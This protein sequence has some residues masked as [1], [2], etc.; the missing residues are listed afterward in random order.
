MLTY[1][2]SEIN[3]PYIAQFINKQVKENIKLC[4]FGGNFFRVHPNN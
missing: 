2:N 3:I 1:P 4:E